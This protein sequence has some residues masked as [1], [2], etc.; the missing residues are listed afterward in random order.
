MQGYADDINS[1]S[2]ALSNDL[3]QATQGVIANLPI[4]PGLNIY[5]PGS[6]VSLTSQ[7]LTELASRLHVRE[8]SLQ[9]AIDA[10][11]GTDSFAQPAQPARLLPGNI[12]VAPQPARSGKTFDPVT[13]RQTLGT[14]APAPTTSTGKKVAV[15]V[16]TTAGVAAVGSWIYAHLTQQAYSVFWDKI[17]K[18]TGKKLLP[19][20]KPN[21]RRRAR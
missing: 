12:P 6:L 4:I 9:S 20:S 14:A 10:F 13:G 8:D 18:E 2:Q 1:A 16:A 5:D 15:A 19:P 7:G 17:W 21:P 3:Q 11:M